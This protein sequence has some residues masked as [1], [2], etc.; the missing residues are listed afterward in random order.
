M[1]WA[2]YAIIELQNGSTATLTPR[3]GS[4]KGKVESGDTVVLEPAPDELIYGIATNVAG[5]PIER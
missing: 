3:G 4:M 2:H 5:V 1:N